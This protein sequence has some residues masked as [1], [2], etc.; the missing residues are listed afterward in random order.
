MISEAA[1]AAGREPDD[2]ERAVNVMQLDG[3]ALMELVD[4]PTELVVAAPVPAAKRPTRSD[5]FPHDTKAS[6]VRLGWPSRAGRR[7][8]PPASGMPRTRP[9][10]SRVRW[11]QHRVK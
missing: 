1:R 6:S 8:A 3:D 5:G 11:Q 4:E 2:V 7:A 10:R 9:P